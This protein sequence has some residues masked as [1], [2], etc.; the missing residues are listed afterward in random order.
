MTIRCL[1]LAY[2]SQHVWKWFECW[3]RCGCSSQWMHL[4]EVYICMSCPLL[5][6]AATELVIVVPFCLWTSQWWCTNSNLRLCTFNAARRCTDGVGTSHGVACS[7]VFGSMM[8]VGLDT[9]PHHSYYNCGC[10][11][12][13]RHLLESHQ[14]QRDAISTWVVSQTSSSYTFASF[15]L[16]RHV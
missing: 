2:C 7:F 8:H 4:H 5:C 3:F 11:L 12:S 6:S 16:T 1:R 15:I 9:A 13:H 10:G 14:H